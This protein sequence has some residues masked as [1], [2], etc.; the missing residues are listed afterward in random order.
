M[1][2]I[3]L[4]YTHKPSLIQQLRG[5]DVVL[6]LVVTWHDPE[7][8][9]QR[10]LIDACILVGV[11]RFAPSEWAVRIYCGIDAYKGK[12]EVWEYLKEVNQNKKVSAH[13]PSIPISFLP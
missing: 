9:A 8:I 7:N 13:D 6:S 1:T 5:V 4:N 10:N 11:R 12:Y 3:K 2:V